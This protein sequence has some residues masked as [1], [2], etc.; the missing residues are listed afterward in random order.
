MRAEPSRNESFRT[1]VA[2][3]ARAEKK[4]TRSKHA[5]FEQSRVQ[6]ASDLPTHR[7]ARTFFPR[8]RPDASLARGARPF[9]RL[10]R[11]GDAVTLPL[12]AAG[13]RSPLRRTLHPRAAAPARRRDLQRALL[14][15]RA[16]RRLH[17]GDRAPDAD[18]RLRISECGFG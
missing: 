16:L 1:R 2:L 13:E 15:P 4:T 5:F 11:R 3:P 17:P 7:G 9:V 8:R 6:K 14:Q 12:P 18:G 10:L